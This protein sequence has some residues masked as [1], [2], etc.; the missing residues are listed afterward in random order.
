MSKLYIGK[1]NL[2]LVIS[3]VLFLCFFSSCAVIGFNTKHKTPSRPFK[4]PRFTEAD[5]LH[6]S[7]NRFR[8]CYD[9][10]FYELSVSFKIEKKAISGSVMFS[11]KAT[12][13]FDTLQIDLYKN[14]QIDS[15]VFD[16]NKLVYYRKHNAVFV[17]FDRTIKKEE[18]FNFVVY[19]QG[20]PIIAK[21]PPWEGGFVW[22]KDKNK[23][24]WASV[25]C[26]VAG[27][28]LWWPSKDH[29]SD[30]P[31]SM[32]MHYTVPNGLSCVANGVQ[33]DSLVNGDFT[34]YTWKVSY[35][36]NTYNTTFYIGKY[37]HFYIPY[38]SDSGSFVMDFYVLKDNY[39]RAKEH[40]MQVPY[41][42]Q[43]FENFY[44]SYPWPR[45]G[46]KLVES[47]YE[48]MEHQT[49]I[50][51]GHKFKNTSWIDADYIILHESAHEWWGNSVSASDYADI[52]IHEGFATYSEAL[53]IE[54]TQG[55]DA[56]LN[57]LRYYAMLIIN[58]RPVIGPYGVNYW[59]YKDIDVYMKGALLLHTL[60]NTINN[61][62]L[63]RD[64]LKTFYQRFAQK[65]AITSDFI[66]IV[67]EKTGKDN[68]E[69]F[70][71]YLYSRTCP[72][73]VWEYYYDIKIGKSYV[74]YKW[75]NANEGFSIPIKVKAD[76]RVFIIRPT[77][78]LQ[79][80]E[81]PYSKSIVINTNE[82]YIANKRTE[83]F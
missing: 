51:Y 53:Y 60:R 36:I 47:S 20:E 61:D 34:T 28:S 27:S 65:T 82:S 46:Y 73:L 63:F 50:A 49:A 52:W 77:N 9:V 5:S 24:T 66:N 29:L 19:Y 70:K 81:L 58:K 6:G 45:D 56:Y 78:K 57:F 75:L 48:G 38:K 17:L 1:N 33:T 44:G 14:M 25:A 72:E 4:Y 41:I 13:N 42:I 83:K 22:D 69:F 11:S 54:A 10:I 7:L 18:S 39:E 80:S 21:K 12:C 59:D 15:I 74:Y 79:K 40:F 31:D 68:T 8:S 35:P 43:Y 55:Y 67:N 26:E 62:S 3:Y 30:E 76:N 2:F 64:I 37:S 71:Q 23:D 32:V 16:R